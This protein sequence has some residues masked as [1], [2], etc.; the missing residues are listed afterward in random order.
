MTIIYPLS[1]L[2]ESFPEFDVKNKVASDLVE[3]FVEGDE[4]TRLEHILHES[5]S[6]FD[7]TLGRWAQDKIKGQC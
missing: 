3:R 5:E 7:G 1:L 2:V 6:P 4:L